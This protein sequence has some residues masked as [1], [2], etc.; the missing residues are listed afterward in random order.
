MTEQVSCVL[1]AQWGDEGKGKLVDL[2]A[3]K[4]DIVARFNGGANAGHTLVVEG[5]KYAFHLVP[6]GILIPN[7]MNVV[8]NGT[9]VHVPTMLDELDALDEGKIDYGGRLL[10]SNR[11]HVLFD[12]HKM[13]DGAQEGRRGKNAIGT[14][15]RGI[16][17]CYATKMN[18]NGI[19][20]GE[21]LDWDHFEARYKS[22]VESMQTLYPVT[23]KDYDTEKELTMYKETYLPRILPMITDTILYI[24]R[25]YNDGKRILAEG[26]NAAM[27]DIDFGTYPAVTSSSTTVGGIAT[28]LGLVPQKV[29][30]WIGV[31]KAYTTRVGKGPF[32]TELPEGD[33]VGD[34][35]CK[36]GRE[37]GTTTGRRRRCGWLDIP[38][39]AYSSLIN[40]YSSINITKLDILNTLKE[41][42]IGTHYKVEGR[43]LEFGEMPCTLGDL[44]KVEV[45]YETLPGWESDISKCR[46]YGELPENATA[47]IDRIEELTKLP[48]SWV[49]VGPDREQ[50]LEKALPA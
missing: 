30:C 4:Y 37:F 14:T 42:Q 46:S 3:Q 2:L 50:M 12:F 26:A 44:E 29:K 5:K 28:G 47:Y 11:A 41:I 16:G 31:V 23:L 17:P 33:A 13:V 20:F 49:G 6:C 27:L 21:L 25:A 19:R 35:L 40:G 15:K 39:L 8:G 22:L 34:L 32:P 45:V 9:V 36:V 10:V 1:G 38:L 18:R 48:V 43:I 24:N 7:V